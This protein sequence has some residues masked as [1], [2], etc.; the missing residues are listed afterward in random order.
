MHRNARTTVLLLAALAL[1]ACDSSTGPG[2][3]DS[4]AQFSGVWSGV[5]ELGTQG[6]TTSVNIQQNGRTVTGTI[7]MAAILPVGGTSLAGEVDDAG[8]LTLVA[9]YPEECRVLTLRLS[10]A[11]GTLD[12][13]AGLNQQSCRT[14]TGLS[15]AVS[16]S[17]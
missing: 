2:D 8:V 16:L 14:P 4:V 15:G 7:S 17:R 11:G 13:T 3:D 9:A 5:A 12:G 10:R 1:G 6:R